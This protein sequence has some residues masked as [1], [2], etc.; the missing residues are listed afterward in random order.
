MKN[1]TILQGLSNELATSSIDGC[2]VWVHAGMSNQS[3]YHDYCLI[4]YVIL[5][6]SCRVTRS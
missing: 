5:L 2:V 3:H 1:T 6:A 4:T